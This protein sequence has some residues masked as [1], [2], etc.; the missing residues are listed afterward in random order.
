MNCRNNTAR[1]FSR[2]VSLRLTGILVVLTLLVLTLDLAAGVLVA[3]T[4]VFLSDRNRTGR[5]NL[6]NPSSTPKEVTINFSFGIP[7]SDSLGNI[8]LDLA[9][10]NVSDPRSALGWI[11][12]F[13]RK[14]ILPPNGSQVVRLVARPPKDLPDGEYWSRIIIQSQ[15]GET[16]LPVASE[17]EQI[18]TQLNMVM[19]TAIALKYRTGDVTAKI[20]LDKVRMDPSDSVVDLYMDL[21]NSGNASYL[22]VMSCRL[23]D[24]ENRQISK[25]EG[26]VAVYR[27]IRR[28]ISMQIPDGVYAKPYTVDLRISNE[29][30]TD[31]PRDEMVFGNEITYTAAVE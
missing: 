26:Y 12:A 23:L 5:I 17:G 18:T 13:P 1:Q 20:R 31:I 11:K 25:Y 16:A 30:R 27:D 8:A 19:R 21:S 9:D 14:V 15:E 10:S 29:G 2:P 3:P 24:A 22:G 4:V 6:E 7:E 28:R